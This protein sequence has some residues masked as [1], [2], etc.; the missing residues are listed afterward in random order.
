M[1]KHTIFVCKSCDFSTQQRDYLGQRG[2]KHLLNQL[3]ELQANWQY[4]DEFIIQEVSCLSACNR[5]CAVAFAAPNKA[6]LMFGDL[7]PMSSPPS[8]LRFA[9]QYLSSND[10][11]IKRQDR[12]EVLQKGILARIPPL[13]PLNVVT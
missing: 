7:P 3:K 8:I 1:S 9:E 12:P 11:L 10:G 4:Q 6:T 13:P 5:P 2:G